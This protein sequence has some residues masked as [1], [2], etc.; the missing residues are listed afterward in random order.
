MKP[1]FAGTFYYLALLNSCD[2]SQAGGAGGM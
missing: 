2:Q 1:C